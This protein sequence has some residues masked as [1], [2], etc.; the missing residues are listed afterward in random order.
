[1]EQN[2]FVDQVCG[3]S[4]GK[5]GLSTS[6]MASVPSCLCMPLP[7][8]FNDVGYYSAAVAPSYSCHV[9]LDNAGKESNTKLLGFGLA[10][11][12]M[13]SKEIQ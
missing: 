6:F 13:D 5:K 12:S 8:D 4:R 11:S 7:Q 10:A 9:V 3:V 1:V 2:P